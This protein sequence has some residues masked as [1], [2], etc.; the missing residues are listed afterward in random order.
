MVKPGSQGQGLQGYSFSL[1]WAGTF[2]SKRKKTNKKWHFSAVDYQNI[3]IS[4]EVEFSGCPGT[5]QCLGTRGRGIR[6]RAERALFLFCSCAF[7]KFCLEWGR[8]ADGTWRTLEGGGGEWRGISFIAFNCWLEAICTTHSGLTDN[9]AYIC[10]GCMM[11]VMLWCWIYCI[12]LM[13]LEV[14]DLGWMDGWN[15]EHKSNKYAREWLCSLPGRSVVWC[16]A[17]RLR[18][19]EWRQWREGGQAEN[20][21]N[22]TCR[23][24]CAQSLVRESCSRNNVVEPVGKTSLVLDTV[25]G[26]DLEKE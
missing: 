8:E 13:M 3:G 20:N 21:N 24:R 18:A 1:L 26:H 9:T 22:P 11:L 15:A 7:S 2:L 14:Y 23:D 25:F 6:A 10:L 19:G 16:V 17:L 4:R 12:M 5:R